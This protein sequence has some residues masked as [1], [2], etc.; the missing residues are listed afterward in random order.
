M[1][2]S[3]ALELHDHYQANDSLGLTREWARRLHGQQKD[4]DGQPYVTH[5]DAVAL[6][7][8]RLFGFDETLIKVAYLH[9]T[10]EDTSCTMKHVA[11]EGFD[12]DTRVA[13]FHITKGKNERNPDYIK[14]VLTNE[15]ASKVKLADITHNTEEARLAT[16]SEDTQARLLAKYLPAKWRLEKDLGVPPTVTFAQAWEAAKYHNKRRWMT[17]SAKTVIVGDLIKITGGDGKVLLWKV[18]KKEIDYKSKT[19]SILTPDGTLL[20][21]PDTATVSFLPDTKTAGVKVFEYFG[22]TSD[23]ECPALLDAEG[24]MSDA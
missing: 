21:L 5:L 10:I 12:P 19:V 9:D 13:L 7:T 4:K 11:D 2:Y 3:T 24:A 1:A 14:R 20:E 6:N 18:V 22:L 8:V 17:C 23:E 16:L 15:I